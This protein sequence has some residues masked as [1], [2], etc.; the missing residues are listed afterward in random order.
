M[1]VLDRLGDLLKKKKDRNIALFIDG[2]NVIRKDMHLDLDAVKKELKKHGKIRIGTVFLDQYAS[3]KLIE[4]M[5]N[6]GYQP[7]ITSGDVD[8]TMACEAIEQIFNPHIDIIALMTRDTDFRPVLVKAKEHGKETIVIGGEPGFSVAL[9]NTAD[10]II[11][12]SKL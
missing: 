11:K 1:T 10:I 6:Q 9:K 4:A 5:I 3:D 7:V 8:V 2:P 12:M